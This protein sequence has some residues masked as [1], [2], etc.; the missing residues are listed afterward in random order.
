MMGHEDLDPRFSRKCNIDSGDDV[1]MVTPDPDQ[2]DKSLPIGKFMNEGKN[3]TRF[4]T[5]K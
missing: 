1:E 4:L 2:P 3:R 5:G